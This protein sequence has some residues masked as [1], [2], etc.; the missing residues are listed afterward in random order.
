MIQVNK[1]KRLFELSFTA[2]LKDGYVY[3][4]KMLAPNLVY[5]FCTLKMFDADSGFKHFFRN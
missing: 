3:V 4:D 5:I 2:T 1:T